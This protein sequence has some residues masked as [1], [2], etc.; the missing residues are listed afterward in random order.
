MVLRLSEKE[1][2]EFISK[3]DFKKMN[4]LVPVVVQDRDNDKV[5]MQAFMNEEALR[6]TLK[7]GRMHY[8]SRTKRRIWLKG[9]ESGHY[10]IVE[11]AILDCDNDSILFKV[12]Q[13]G[14]CCHTGK[15][16]CFHNLLLSLEEK[17][18][19]DGRFLEKIYEV[20]IERIEN[21]NENSYVSKLISKGEDAIL[22]KIGE[23]AF[24]LVLA[25]KKTDEKEV[26]FEASDLIFHIL[27]LLASKGI[28]L[29][30]IFKELEERH[31]AKTCK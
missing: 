5:L 30:K 11:N 31:K 6:L 26:V 15:E 16:S 14:V 21:F 27:I 22:Q 4:G 8:W 20:I 7:T 25:S 12:H 28:S 19:L 29:K 1:I 24:E 3:V 9:E 23:E 17:E 13:I 10:S 2:E 18:E